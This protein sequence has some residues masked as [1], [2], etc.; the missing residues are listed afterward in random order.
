VPYVPV[1]G[2]LVCITQMVFLDWKTWLRC[3]AWWSIGI[4]WSVIQL[5]V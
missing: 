2:S 1:A 3:A 4:A 5:C